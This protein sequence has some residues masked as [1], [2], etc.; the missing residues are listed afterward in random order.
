[1]TTMRRGACAGFIGEVARSDV[2]LIQVA[3]LGA[4]ALNVVA[5]RRIFADK[6]F[7]FHAGNRLSIMLGV[8]DSCAGVQ[9]QEL[10][11]A[12]YFRVGKG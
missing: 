7:L 1:M 6:L 2:L 9:Q 12:L 8:I 4:A 3:A 11:P 5:R 10:S